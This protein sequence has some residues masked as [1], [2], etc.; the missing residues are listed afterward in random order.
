MMQHPQ[1]TNKAEPLPP[2]R[3]KEQEEEAV[4]A[5]AT[6]AGTRA[7]AV[8]EKPPG[9]GVTLDQGAKPLPKQLSPSSEEQGCKS[10]I[11]VP[12]A[13]QPSP[14][15]QTQQKARGQGRPNNEMHGDPPLETQGRA[16]GAE[17]GSGEGKEE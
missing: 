8:G 1:T 14:S 6:A 11:Y 5:S 10:Q 4:T 7:G 16:E 9:R 3:L 15:G 12:P 2:L 13:S 17:R